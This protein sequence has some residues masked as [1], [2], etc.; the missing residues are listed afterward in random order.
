LGAATAVTAAPLRIDERVLH[1][2]AGVDYLDERLAGRLRTPDVPAPSAEQCA[3]AHHLLGGRAEGRAL[4]VLLA[5]AE[6]VSQIGVSAAVSQMA[7]APLYVLAAEDIPSA[8]A[9]RLSF[10]RLCDR[11][12][13]LTGALLFVP[14]DAE[15]AAGVK[16]LADLMQAPVIVAA[17]EPL[18]TSARLSVVDVTPSRWR[19]P[20]ANG[21]DLLHESRLSEELAGLSQRIIPLATWDDLVLPPAQLALLRQMAGQVRRAEQVYVDW[22]FASKSHRGLGISAL[23]S[24]PSGTGKTMA[25]EVLANELGRELYQID[26]SAVTS[27]YI[28]ETEKNLSRI[29][30]AAEQASAIL[31]FD[32]ADALFGKRSEVKD[33]H[34]RYAN[35]E[36]SYL[37]QRM[38]AYSG[39]AVLTTNFRSALDPAFLRRI[40]FIVD[41]PFPD[42]AARAEIWCKVFPSSMPRDGIDVPRLSRLAVAGGSIRN[43]AL[44]AAFLA[45]D[46]ESVVGMSHLLYAA[47]AEYAKLERPQGEIDLVNRA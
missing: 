3:L 16:A 2:L 27:K 6:P 29:F 1:H 35:M 23:F 46:D 5:G 42:V 28:G 15:H 44:N 13:A 37:L 8:P 38:E 40:R 33:S 19:D 26:L 7:G 10:A 17:R 4:A 36:V 30:A 24:G 43:I 9:E 31:F 25:A 22:G 21:R 41:F 45:A 12:A 18:R 39:L 11:E 20:G 14:C 32:E 34:D 47:R